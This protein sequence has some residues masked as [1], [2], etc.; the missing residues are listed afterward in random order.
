MKRTEA[1]DMIL[2]W[3]DAIHLHPSTGEAGGPRVRAWTQDPV[4]RV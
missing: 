3:M 1:Q 2:K 4:A